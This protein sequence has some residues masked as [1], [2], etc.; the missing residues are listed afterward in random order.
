MISPVLPYPTSAVPDA[1]AHGLVFGDFCWEALDTNHESVSG[2]M[3]INVNG[4]NSA[5]DRPVLEA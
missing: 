1:S 4:N 3:L 5:N 2:T